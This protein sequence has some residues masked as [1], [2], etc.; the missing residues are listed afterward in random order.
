MKLDSYDLKVLDQAE[1]LLETD[2]QIKKYPLR[3]E[4]YIES[5]N[6]ISMIEELIWTI[7]HLKEE[8]EEEEI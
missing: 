5:D 3:N 7:E 4:G 8:K 1:E 2:F 6:L